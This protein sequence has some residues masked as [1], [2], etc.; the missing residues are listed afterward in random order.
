MP[1]HPEYAIIGNGR[2]AHRMHG[3]LALQSKVT[4]V[5]ET[6]RHN[7]ESDREYRTRMGA[8]LAKTR[9]QAAWICVPPNPDTLLLAAASIDNGMHVIAEKPWV[10]ERQDSH[11]LAAQAHSQGVVIGVHYEYCLLE[12]V[13]SWRSQQKG[14]VGLEFSGRFATSRPDRLGIPAM[15]NL[16]SHLFAIRA[17]AIPEAGISTIDCGYD[18]AE[19]RLVWL[20]SG[21]R[22]IA[23]IDFSENREPVI[24]RFIARFESALEGGSF[25]FD[26]D[27]AAQVF[28]SLNTFR[29]HAEGST[30]Q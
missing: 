12:G 21:D 7:R 9:A 13:E 15:E 10:W 8:S 29:H 26:L 24:Q 30:R 20:A 14:G 5:Q 4:V 2:W 25:P 6:R 18:G 3:I 11:A 28:E 16:G 17:Y 23:T 22:S 27:F 19:E 1:A